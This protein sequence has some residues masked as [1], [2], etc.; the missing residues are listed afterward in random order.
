MIKKS[1]AVV[2]LAYA[3]FIWFL[4]FSAGDPK[5]QDWAPIAAGVYGF[6]GLFVFAAAGFGTTMHHLHANDSAEN[7]NDTKNSV[8]PM[9]LF[10]NLGWVLILL[11]LFA[12]ATFR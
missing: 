11:A 10:L 1:I 3:V 5:N 6:F 4:A 2:A 9:I 8:A 12:V 7:A